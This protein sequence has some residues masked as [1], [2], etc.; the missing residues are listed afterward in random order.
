VL[1]IA[2]GALRDAQEFF[3][4]AG[5]D[6]KEGTGVLGGFRSKRG[7]HVTRFFAPDQVVGEGGACW[8]EV[9]DAGKLASAMALQSDERW[10]ARI[11]SHPA[12]AF[13]SPVDDRNPFLT[14]EGAWSIVVPYFGLG[15]RRGLVSC[16]VLRRVDGRWRRLSPTDVE[17]Q[18]RILP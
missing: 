15:L 9:T 6:G 10:I 14:A 13:H 4:A 8:V 12:E 2:R 17:R 11:H 1:E 7:D 18:V 16:A 5:V 3:E